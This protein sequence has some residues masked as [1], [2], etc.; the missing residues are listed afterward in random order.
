MRIEV[1]GVGRRRKNAPA[2]V[3]VAKE[4]ESARAG[5]GV[6]RGSLDAHIASAADARAA[7]FG[8]VDRRRRRRREP[9]IDEETQRL[10]ARGSHDPLLAGLFSGASRVVSVSSLD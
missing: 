4:E 9:F 8:D 5:S 7:E 10:F 6:S 3:V 2:A 1:R